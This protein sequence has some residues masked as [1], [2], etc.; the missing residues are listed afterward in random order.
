MESNICG[1]PQ[2]LI[3]PDH[4]FHWEPNWPSSQKCP[5]NRL[6][7]PC[8]S[9]TGFHIFLGTKSGDEIEHVVELIACPIL[10][11]SIW[12]QSWTMYHWCALNAGGQYLRD[13]FHH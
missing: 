11:I 1:V 12:K 7:F 3:L 13:D 2:L 9:I 6:T 10:N 5:L 4:T 8:E